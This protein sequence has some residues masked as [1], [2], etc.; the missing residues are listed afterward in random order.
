MEYVA[1]HIV[2]YKIWQK[3]KRDEREHGFEEPDLDSREV[4]LHHHEMGDQSNV[5]R[6]SKYLAE[7]RGRKVREEEGQNDSKQASIANWTCN[8]GC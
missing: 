3:I 6:L 4:Q 5:P 7:S 2:D 1:V 8:L